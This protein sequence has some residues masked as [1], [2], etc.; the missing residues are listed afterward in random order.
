MVPGIPRE[1]IRA[2]LSE[3]Q[4]DDLLSFLL[5]RVYDVSLPKL[6][7]DSRECVLDHVD[8]E[9]SRLVKKQVLVRF[10]LL[11]QRRA[12][13]GGVV[14]QDQ[15]VFVVGEPTY[16]C[17]QEAK[18][19][20]SIDLS[21]EQLYG[22][23][24]LRRTESDGCQGGVLD[25]P[26]VQLDLGLAVLPNPVVFGCLDQRVLHLVHVQHLG[27]RV[28]VY[29]GHGANYIVQSGLA[30]WIVRPELR[31]GQ[32]ELPPP[33]VERVEDLQDLLPRE[34]GVCSLQVCNRCQPSV[35][36]SDV[37]FER[38][39]VCWILHIV[40][41]VCLWLSLV[42][43]TPVDLLDG[44]VARLGMFGHLLEV[45]SVLV[46]DALSDQ[47][48]LLVDLGFSGQLGSPLS[49]VGLEVSESS[50][51]LRAVHAGLDQF[52]D[53]CS[54]LV[55]RDVWSSLHSLLLETL[56]LHDLSLQELGHVVWSRC[57]AVHLGAGPGFEW[58]HAFTAFLTV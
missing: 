21:P 37:C 4:V 30:G 6:S 28:A 10:R 2:V 46:T 8:L 41:L 48:T 33:Q 31:F 40:V 43:Q 16:R 32:W 20:L 27:L 34:T 56:H 52:L 45:E 58:W 5:H 7:P 39:G 42:D 22:H 25:V 49:L 36:L 1:P 18:E 57:L 17:I 19:V 26:S 12:V 35:G 47:T 3:E 24:P 11:H 53:Q 38:C 13:P 50:G 9:H 55:L 44:L 15:I 23:E 51:S 14:C 29:L 54:G